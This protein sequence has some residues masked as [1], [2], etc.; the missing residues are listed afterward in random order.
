VVAGG[1]RL[2]DLEAGVVAALASVRFSVISGG[3]VC[4]LGALGIARWAPSFVRYLPPEAGS[5][6]ERTEE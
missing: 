5:Q 2:G 6:V 3:L 1:P 4:V